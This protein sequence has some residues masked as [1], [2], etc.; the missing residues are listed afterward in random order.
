MFTFRNSLL[1]MRDVHAYST[2]GAERK[3][4][5]HRDAR[6]F[7]KQLAAAL[8]LVPGSYDIR[9]NKGGMAVSG[10]VTLHHERLYVWMQ[11]SCT[12]P[13]LIL[14]CRSCK[15]RKDYTGGSNHQEFVANLETA[16]Q[17]RF[18][19]EQCQRLIRLGGQQ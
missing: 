3:A 11:E 18:F 5:F 19:V 8:D 10:E 6:H 17:R 1:T 14:V 9:S 16:S 13:G 12:G 4:Q 15:G 2:E 7:F